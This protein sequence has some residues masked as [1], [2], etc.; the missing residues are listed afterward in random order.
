[1]PNDDADLMRKFQSAIAGAELGELRQLADGLGLLAARAAVP[2]DRPE[3]R[4]PPRQQ[5]DVFRIR[6]D[7]DTSKPA[8]WR[9]L[10][11]R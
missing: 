10:D 7:L 9:R 4:R 5:V 8:I 2:L 3:L 6:V 1:M 11:L